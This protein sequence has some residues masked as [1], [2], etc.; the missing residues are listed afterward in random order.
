[1]ALL[2]LIRHGEPTLK[3]VFLGQLDPPLSA[4]G[5]AQVSVMLSTLE[6]NAA[7]YSPLLRARQTA[8]HLVC[9]DKVELAHLREIDYGD[10]TGKTW[11]ELERD[12]PEL[13]ARKTADW[14]GV[15]APNGET[16]PCFLARVAQA[17]KMMQG[18]SFPLA[19]VAHQAVN[20]ALLNLVNGSD[21]LEFKQE[22]G[23]VISVSL[24]C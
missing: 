16:W 17:W 15:P 12:W 4:A 11:A 23:Q 8:D 19:I 18:R 7:F 22:Y 20:A 5:H 14:L 2:H 13:T 24:D 1:M 21:V 6:V 3:G 10:W 9:A